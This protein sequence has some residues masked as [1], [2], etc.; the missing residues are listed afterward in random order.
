MLETRRYRTVG[1]ARC[2][3]L[4]LIVRLCLVL[5]LVSSLPYYGVSREKS[6]KRSIKCKTAAIAAQCYWTRGRLAFYKGTPSLRL[7]KI[8]TRRLLGIYSGPSVSPY[9]DHLDNEAPELPPAVQNL[10]EP[11]ENLSETEGR[12][13]TNKAAPVSHNRLI[14][15]VGPTTLTQSPRSAPEKR[16]VKPQSAAS[17]KGE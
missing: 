14:L 12:V 11:S 10:F 3:I 6:S 1:P 5:I 16:P 4:V 2:C 15:I 9:N 13:G 17:S 7:W 8:G